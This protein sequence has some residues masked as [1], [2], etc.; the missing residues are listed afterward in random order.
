VLV[1]QTFRQFGPVW[2]SNRA[3]FRWDSSV[4]PCAL[5]VSH[6][7]APYAEWH[8]NEMV[9]DVEELRKLADVVVIP[10]TGG[11]FIQDPAPSE[12]RLARRLTDEGAAL[13]IGH[14]P[15]F[16]RGVERRGKAASHIAWAS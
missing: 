15:H 1:K 6:A 2:L 12:N 14:H 13:V 9:R 5:A 7:R 4:S 3:A 10:C 16:R 8:P 11:E